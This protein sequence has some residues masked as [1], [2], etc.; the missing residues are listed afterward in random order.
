MRKFIKG[1]VAVAVVVAGALSGAQAL[2]EGGGQTRPPV[3]QL[4]E[5]GG[6]TRPPVLQ[7]AVSPVVA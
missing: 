2:A 7:L 1:S 4:A 6:Q 3:L 5:G